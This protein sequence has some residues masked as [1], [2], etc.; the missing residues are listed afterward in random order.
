MITKPNTPNPNN[1][2]EEGTQPTG[3][4]SFRDY[5]SIGTSL[6]AIVDGCYDA[7]II[8][9]KFVPHATD[10]EKDYLRLEVQLADRVTVENRFVSG[11]FIFER[12]IK[13]Q[14]GLSDVSMPVAELMTK[15]LNQPIKIWYKSQKS[16]KDNRTYQNMYFAEP[17]EAPV[18][19][20]ELPKY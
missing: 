12:E 17:V 11:Y 20:A 1:A 8:A 2:V 9:L 18:A 15:I 16:L 6:K 4:L 14:L 7:K 10:P 5:I 3:K 13:K 19:S